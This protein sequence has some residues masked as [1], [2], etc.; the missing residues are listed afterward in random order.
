M[1]KPKVNFREAIQGRGEFNYLHKKQSGGAGQ[2]GRVIGYIEPLPE[3]ATERYEFENACVGNNIPPEFFPACV[4]GFREAANSGALIGAPVD[5][6]RVVLTDGSS[7]PVDSNEMAF[8][9]ASIQGFR[10]AYAAAGATILEPI[11][12]VE[13]TVPVEFQGTA[14]GD[15]NRRKGV[16]L[17][18]AQ[19][20]E[21]A[22]IQAQVPLNNMFGYS[23]VLRSNTQG[24]GEFA[25]EYAH[26]APVTRELQDTLTAH[27]E[28]A[29]RSGEK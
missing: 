16:I 23:T 2:F 8:K 29:R 15:L 19:N 14:M 3:G 4:K 24:K 26:H 7:H 9:L 13:V 5:G 20:V 10:Q 12:N 21:D 27:Y 25:M 18:S 1:G 6:V 11:M 17:D 22:V 28:K